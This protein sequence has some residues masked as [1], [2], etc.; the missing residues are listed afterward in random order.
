[1]GRMSECVVRTRTVG[2][3]RAGTRKLVYVLI[4]HIVG[5]GDNGGRPEKARA[6]SQIDRPDAGN[7]N[8]LVPNIQPAQ[9]IRKDAL[10]SKGERLFVG[11]FS[12]VDA[13]GCV[14]RGGSFGARSHRLGLHRI[15]RVRGDADPKAVGRVVDALPASPVSSRCVCALTK[16]GQMTAS[17]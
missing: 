14:D 12:Q 16:P 11:C 10:P 15:G 5:M 2:Y 6:K 1:M 7:G 17:P 13:D 3:G 8:R 4:R 9:V